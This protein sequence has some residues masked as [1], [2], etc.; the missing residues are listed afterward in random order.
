MPQTPEPPEPGHE[1]Q[2][3]PPRKRNIGRVFTEAGDEIAVDHLYDPDPDP[4]PDCGGDCIAAGMIGMTAGSITVTLIPE[5]A[6]LLA[7]RLERAV[8][9]VLETMEDPPD[10]ER[11]MARFAPAGPGEPPQ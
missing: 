11:D 5:E 10:I 3:R 4:C 7:S 8:N 9:V 2:H 6:L 1:H